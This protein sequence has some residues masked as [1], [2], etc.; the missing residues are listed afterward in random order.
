MN[1]LVM[2]NKKPKLTL[3]NDAKKKMK[4]SI[5]FSNKSEIVEISKAESRILS[6]DIIAKF[7]I[8]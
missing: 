2:M 4:D 3:A 6:R 8:P 1:K 7:N 5:N